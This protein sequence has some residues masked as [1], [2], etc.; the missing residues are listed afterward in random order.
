VRAYLPSAADENW[1][2][3]KD[4]SER[5][6][7]WDPLKY[8]SLGSEDRFLTLS[9]EIRFRLE[10]FRVR[11][12]GESPATI[13]TYLLQ[14]YLWGADLNLSRRF[15]V[16]AESQG[17]IINGNLKSPRPTDEDKLDL[18]QAF[19]ELKGTIRGKRMIGLKLGRQELAIG[20]SRLI[21]AS[22]GLNV[23]R[24]F[25]GA[26]FRFLS[27]SWRLHAA[28][29][30]LVSISKNYF[31]DRPDHEETF[32]GASASRKSPRFKQGEMSFY[33]LGVDRLQAEYAQGTGRDLRHTLG[34]K[35][36]GSGQQLDLNY[37]AIFQWGRF[38]E[39]SA[40]AWALSTETGY[41]L[42]SRRWRPRFSVRIE[43]RVVMGSQPQHS[44]RVHQR[45]VMPLEG[46][47]PVKTSIAFPFAV[48]RLH[49]L[50]HPATGRR[51]PE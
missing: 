48:S 10:G 32:W 5:N 34:V 27:D 19:F 11:A 18:H 25:D 33:Y 20:S 23:K 36:S 45:P 4:R 50:F 35:W 6:D 17:G 14:R 51:L 47:W 37:D 38:R 43:N 2:F 13:D 21:S 26:V 9:A 3:L 41:R 46:C 28:A 22:P 7:F 16:F 24:S 49:S 44:I 30:K 29:A 31:D 1:S 15:R 12:A 39:A 40:R 42:V 8:I